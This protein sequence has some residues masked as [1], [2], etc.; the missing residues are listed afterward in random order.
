MTD[1]RGAAA[2]EWVLLAPVVVLL[3]GVLVAGGRL[4][5]ARSTVA[6]A[7]H[8][9]ARAASLQ[10]DA[11]SADGRARDVARANIAGTCTDP[12]VQPDVSAFQLPPGT[13]GRITTTVTCRVALD[14]LLVPGLPGTVTVTATG[15]AVLDAYRERR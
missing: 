11:A 12:V 10:R 9:G 4:S 1:E 6:D 3:L 7:A 2:T 5:F 15:V 8:A 14:D 13:T